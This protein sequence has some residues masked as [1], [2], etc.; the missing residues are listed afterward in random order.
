MARLPVAATKCFDQAYSFL[1]TDVFEPHKPFSPLFASQDLGHILCRR[2]L[3]SEKYLDFYQR[4][5]VEKK[6]KDVMEQLIKMREAPLLLNQCSALEFENHLNSLSDNA[7]E[8]MQSQKQS[9]TNQACVF[10]NVQDC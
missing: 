1:T 8:V 9:K 6:V 2:P 4:F 10:R 7:E 5:A 3:A